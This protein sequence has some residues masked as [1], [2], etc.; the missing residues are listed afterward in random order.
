MS[1]E[2]V[3]SGGSIGSRWTLTKVEGR[4]RNPRVYSRWKSTGV[5]RSS[6]KLKLPPK[7]VVEDSVVG[8]WWK[9]PLP[10]KK[11]GSFHAFSWK[12]P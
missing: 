11:G 7:V 12:L 8:C 5:Y 1:V 10:P 3:E 4:L 9:L 6:W 2:S